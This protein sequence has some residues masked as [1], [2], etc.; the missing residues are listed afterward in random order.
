MQMGMGSQ[1]AETTAPKW[2]VDTK[3]MP[4]VLRFVFRGQLS[5]QEV[6]QFVV[7]HNR[8]VDETRGRDY[9]VWVDLREMLPLSPEA[10]QALEKAKRYS[11]AQ[12]NFRGSAVL[13]SGATVA[14]QHRRTSD[15]GGVGDTEFISTDED[16]CRRYLSTVYRGA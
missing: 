1:Q 15:S 3:T 6:E 5:L 13:V 11:A 4:G 2:L 14:L 8:A 16:D 12:P 7:A 10:T 9:K